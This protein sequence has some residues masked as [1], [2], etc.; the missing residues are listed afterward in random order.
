MRRYHFLKS[1][2]DIGTPHQGPHRARRGGSRGTDVCS[3]VWVRYR[4]PAGRSGKE[5]VGML[6]FTLQAG[7]G[8]VSKCL[9]AGVSRGLFDENSKKRVYALDGI[10]H[11]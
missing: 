2:S 9:F 10:S 3:L 6:Y 11:M 4:L 8:K 5:S 7:Y 1:T